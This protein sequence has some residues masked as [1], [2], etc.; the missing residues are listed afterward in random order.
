MLGNSIADG[1]PVRVVTVMI[2]FIDDGELRWA[3]VSSP[4]IFAVAGRATGLVNDGAVGVGVVL[5]V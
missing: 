2:R 4:Q 1:R 3:L 5:L